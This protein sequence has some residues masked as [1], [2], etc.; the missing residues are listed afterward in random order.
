MPAQEMN[1]W[2]I[3]APDYTVNKRVVKCEIF[4]GYAPKTKVTEKYHHIGNTS[5]KT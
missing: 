4:S 1:G 3:T 5:T 2:R